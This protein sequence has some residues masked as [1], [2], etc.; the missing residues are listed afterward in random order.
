MSFCSQS[1]PLIVFWLFYRPSL[2]RLKSELFDLKLLHLSLNSSS[3]FGTIYFPMRLVVYKL[4]SEFGF[5]YS[6]DVHIGLVY[7]FNWGFIKEIKS[8]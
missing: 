4:I 6:L 7:W 3:W 1:V 8:V 2:G 5:L